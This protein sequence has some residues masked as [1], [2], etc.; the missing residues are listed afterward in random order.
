[1]PLSGED[2]QAIGDYTLLDRIGS[3]GMGTV[4]AAGSPTGR[5]V[6]LKVVHQQFADDEEFRGRFHQEVA[7]AR[8]VSGAFTAA[9][10]DA[11]P[12]AVRPWM[13]TAF[14][15]GP[16]LADRVRDQ[17][18]LYGRELRDLAV[19]LVEALRDIHRAGL[20]HRDLKPANIVLSQDG[21]RVIDFGISRAADNQALTMTGRVLGTPPFM[22]PEQLQSPR[23][24]GPASDVFSLAAV[25]VFAATGR[26]PF[27]ADSPYLT[28][29]HVVH[30][31]PDLTGVPDALRAAVEPCLAKEEADRAS[32]DTLLTELLRLPTTDAAPPHPGPEPTA[33][34]TAGT[35]GAARSA[36]TATTASPPARRPRTLLRLLGGALGLAVVVGGGAVLLHAPDAASGGS[37]AEPSPSTALPAGWHAWQT[38]LG[39]TTSGAHADAQGCVVHGDALY[40]V[41]GRHAVARV[42][43]ADGSVAWRTGIPQD[44]IR[45]LGVTDRTV[46]TLEKTPAGGFVVV[47]RALADGGIVWQQ[48]MTNTRRFAAMSDG[49][50]FAALPGDRQI[51]ALRATDGTELWRADR[52]A[53]DCDLYAYGGTLY[54]ACETGDGPHRILRFGQDDGAAR[55]LASTP[56]P[57]EP[58]GLAGNDIVALV[59]DKTDEPGS[60]TKLVRI[61]ATTGEPTTTPITGIVPS[62]RA[63]PHLVGGIVY[64]VLGTGKVDAVDA[65]SAR[66]LW[67]RPGGPESLG[68]AAAPVLNARRDEAYFLSAKDRL[69]AIEPSTGLIK[70]RGPDRPA[71]KEAGGMRSAPS[72]T[73]VDDTLLVAAHGRLLS[74]SPTAPSARPRTN[75]P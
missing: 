14:I 46:V 62:T 57:V 51:V 19:G 59:T 13:A 12:D 28:A 8:R 25:L 6:A 10:V 4:Y 67:T 22:S 5:R 21:P 39:T 70:W 35:S 3:G 36:T 58:I 53:G 37:D 52:P 9:V 45:P 54:G 40:C 2:P 42:D 23:A 38:V 7:A 56:D 69:T 1:M 48:G 73:L 71:P 72:L 55:Q 64:F 31:Q 74:V 65:V 49:T 41:D 33:A 29:Y 66:H 34:A 15:D 43:A 63:T 61:G 20:V 16:T 18:A 75:A 11:D 32:L 60:Y 50:V 24:A 17:G 44:V 27:D 47:G 68:A 30:E 26:G